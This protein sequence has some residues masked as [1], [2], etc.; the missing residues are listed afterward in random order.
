M[1]KTFFISL[2][3]AALLCGCERTDYSDRLD[4]LSQKID[5]LSKQ[6]P[7]TN[8]N[9]ELVVVDTNSVVYELNKTTGDMMY[10]T[11]KETKMLHRPLTYEELTRGL[12]LETNTTNATSSN[13]N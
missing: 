7:A 4:A 3:L 11:G 12:P 1:P 8:G 6:A 2:A 5:A 13:T 9:Y 10:I